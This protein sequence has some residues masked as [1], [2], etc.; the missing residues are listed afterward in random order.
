MVKGGWQSRERWAIP[1]WLTAT[2][3]PCTR[4]GH[5][6]LCTSAHERAFGTRRHCASWALPPQQGRWQRC[7]SR[8]PVSGSYRA[9]PA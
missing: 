9:G 1:A 7:A 3:S 6:L 8:S 5:A 2:S 4:P